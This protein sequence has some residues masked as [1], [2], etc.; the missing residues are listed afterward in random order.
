MKYNVRGLTTQEVENSRTQHGFNELTPQEVEGFW[1]KL[2]GNFK[3]PIILI[4]VVALVLMVTLAILGFAPW[5]EGVA[6]AIAVIIAVSVATWSEFKNETSFQKLQ[7]E[8]SRT[9]VKVFRNGHISEIY[10]ADIVVGDYVLLQPGDKVPADGKIIT[11]ELKMNQASLTG[12]ADHVKKMTAPDGYKPEQKNNLS[13]PYIVFRGS[14]VEEGEVIIQVDT[15]GDNSLYGQLARE[16]APEERKTPLQVKLSALASGISKFGF[17]GGTLIA[18]AFIFKKVVMDNHFVISEIVQYFSQWQIFLHDTVTAVTLAAII[19]V[20]AV[21]EGLPMMIAIVLSLNMRKLLNA[22][23]LVRKLLGMETA[24]SLNIL[25]SDKTGT[26]TKG[27]MEVSLFMTGNPK[28]Y[29]TFESIP[30]KLRSLLALSLRGNTDC[31]IDVFKS[32]KEKVFGGNRV[33]RALMEFIHITLSQHPHTIVHET[34]PFDSNR[35]FSAAHVTK[36]NEKITLVK[37]APE[38]ILQNC[39]YYY[40]ENGNK[41]KINDKSALTQEINRLSDRGMRVIA[42]STSEGTTI[43]DYSCPLPRSLVGVIGLRDEIRKESASAIKQAQEAGIQV[44]MITGDKKETAVAIAREVGLLKDSNDIILTSSEINRLSDEK[45]K[46]LMPNLRVVARALPTDKSRLVK[47]AQELHL[48]VGMTGDGI[49][50]SAALNKADV[51]FAMGSGTEVAKE[52]GDIVILD[53]NFSSITKAILYGRTIFNSIR[54]FIVFQLTVNVAAISIAFLGPFLGYDL[55][56]TMIQLLWVNLIMDTLAAL[57]FGSEAALARYMSEKP[58]RRDES[59]I[60]KDMWS[61]ILLNGGMVVI[62]SIIFLTYQPIK[63]LFHSEAAFMTG[64]FAFFVFVHN[65]NKFNARTDRVNLFDHLFENK[66]FLGIV[67]L[68]FAVQI[69]F[70]YLGGDILRTVGLTFGE[71]MWITLFSIVI[72]PFDMTRKLIRNALANRAAVAR[73]RPVFDSHR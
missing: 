11:G 40:D 42:V 12:E 66:G 19:I 6:I 61:S 7:E 60:N 50:D 13:D 65:F 48:V 30:E 22:K 31:V 67:M 46:D 20:V 8:A 35:K 23:V 51:G 58:K 36:E 56:L 37:G 28:T 44:V 18:F 39:D 38:I 24:G 54:K 70:T 2:I 32:G 57:A 15:V 53:D 62:M 1:N 14:V 68:I 10:I 34:I 64:F 4:L 25:F 55:P 52:A 71:W 5:Y 43:D 3:D 69:I 63:T 45:L 27:Q 72:I 9:K 73:L 17:I 59:I 21:P 47:I 33:D 49:N 41:E 26:I 29:K 16:L